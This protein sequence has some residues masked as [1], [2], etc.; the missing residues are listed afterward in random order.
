MSTHTHGHVLEL[1]DVDAHAADFF[2]IGASFTIEDE[3]S[4]FRYCGCRVV[5]RHEAWHHIAGPWHGGTCAVTFAFLYRTPLRPL[6][7]APQ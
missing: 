1:R 4:G 2:A 3:F 5:T 7:K 6:L